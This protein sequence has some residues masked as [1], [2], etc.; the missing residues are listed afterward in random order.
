[1]TGYRADLQDIFQ[2]SLSN[3]AEVS[4]V[5][6]QA[7]GLRHQFEQQAQVAFAR[8]RL[9]QVALPAGGVA[10][11]NSPIQA[12]DEVA[13]DKR[14]SCKAGLVQAMGEVKPSQR[15]LLRLWIEL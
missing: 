7:V 14:P 15:G 12:A 11:C 1:M 13:I 4:T 9:R 10:H 5:G 8:Q 2:A 3:G 6:D